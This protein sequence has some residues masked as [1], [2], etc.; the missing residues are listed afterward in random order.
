VTQDWPICLFQG[1]FFSVFALRLVRLPASAAGVSAGAAQVAPGA[2]ALI[3]LH[4]FG[5]FVLYLGVARAVFLPLAVTRLFAPR[6]E[7][8]AAIIVLASLLVGWTLLVFQSWRLEARI[9]PGHRLCTVGPFRLV[10]H[11]ICLGTGLLSLGTF[12]W[13]P[14]AMVLGGVLLSLLAA[15]LRARS[16]ERILER[17]FSPAYAVRVK[18]FVP[19]VY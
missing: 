17:A 19:G 15:D 13:I 7:V 1:L 8:G 12:L 2:K 10:R 5:F 6:R 4:G 18:R 14:T 3:A 9:E 11:P 16:E